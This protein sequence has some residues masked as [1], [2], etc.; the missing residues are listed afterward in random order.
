[1]IGKF[2]EYIWHFFP[3]HSRVGVVSVNNTVTQVKP[4][5]KIWENYAFRWQLYQG[6][7]KFPTGT[8]SLGDAVIEA[9]RVS[10]HLVCSCKEGK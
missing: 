10:I 6:L 7:P 1:M 4:C 3:T 5:L 8:S 2:R 9:I